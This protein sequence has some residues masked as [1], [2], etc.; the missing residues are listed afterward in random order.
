LAPIDCR[1]DIVHRAKCTEHIFFTVKGTS[2]DRIWNHALQKSLEGIE[3]RPKHV[4]RDLEVSERTAADCLRTM[5]EQG[6]LEKEGGAGKDPVR[7]YL[8]P[9]LPKTIPAFTRP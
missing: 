6:W 2:R 3:L 4:A 5:A 8:G 9:R 7:F 1:E